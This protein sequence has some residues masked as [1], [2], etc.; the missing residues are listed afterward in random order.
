MRFGFSCD[1]FFGSRDLACAPAR[2]EIRVL[3]L[4][5]DLASAVVANCNAERNA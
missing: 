1:D 5:A 3:G 2:Q 4:D